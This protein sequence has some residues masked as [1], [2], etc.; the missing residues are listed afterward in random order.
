M[1]QATLMACRE[2]KARMKVVGDTLVNPTWLELVQ[3]CNAA[4]V[5]LT[6]RHM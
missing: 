1:F 2:L 3:A 5:D 4:G 6:G